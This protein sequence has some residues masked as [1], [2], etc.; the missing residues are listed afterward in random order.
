VGGV[1]GVGGV[2]FRTFV[3]VHTTTS[4]RATAPSIFVPVTEAAGRPFCV[5]STRES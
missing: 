2:P 1:G 3:K 4:P 5:Q